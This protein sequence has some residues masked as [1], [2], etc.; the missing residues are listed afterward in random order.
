[1]GLMADRVSDDLD[2]GDADG[3]KESSYVAGFLDPPTLDAVKDLERT[4]QNQDN[5][6]LDFTDHRTANILPR[7]GGP[8]RP[9]LRTAVDQESAVLLSSVA[10]DTADILSVKDHKTDT[11]NSPRIEKTPSFESSIDGLENLP[12]ES[13]V[14][15]PFGGEV[16]PGRPFENQSTDVD[17]LSLISAGD[18]VAINVTAAADETTSGESAS[19]STEDAAGAVRADRS[20]WA[21]IDDLP[22]AEAEL[23][24]VDMDPEAEDWEVRTDQPADDPEPWP[25]LGPGAPVV[26]ALRSLPDPPPWPV[27]SDAIEPGPLG[28]FCSFGKRGLQQLEPFSWPVQGSKRFSGVEVMPEA[29]VDDDVFGGGSEVP[30]LHGPPHLDHFAPASTDPRMNVVGVVARAVGAAHDDSNVFSMFSEGEATAEEML[31]PAQSLKTD[32]SLSPTQES[33]TLDHNLRPPSPKPE[34][35]PG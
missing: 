22:S 5:S 23:L 26:L 8:A 27:C 3:V 15:T 17:L 12:D 16:H 19:P 34:G 7:H 13:Q 1:M 20:Q 32:S 35:T 31:A 2:G 4:P 6:I 24:A 21:D 18:F 30:A 28:V 11:G 10:E 25:A 9:Y 29:V 14:L 33:S